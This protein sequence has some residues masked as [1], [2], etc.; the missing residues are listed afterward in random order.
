MNMTSWGPRARP[1]GKRAAE[2]GVVTGEA[3]PQID[4]V[5]E[6]ESRD[7]DLGETGFR[8]WLSRVSSPI[9]SKKLK[10]EIDEGPAR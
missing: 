6:M 1:E 8:V 10:F 9:A 4:F 3:Q 5:V 7:Y 2:A